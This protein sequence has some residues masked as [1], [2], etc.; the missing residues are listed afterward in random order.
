MTSWLLQTARC[1]FWPKLGRILFIES[2]TIES[3]QYFHFGTL[4]YRGLILGTTEASHLWV[5]IE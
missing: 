4:R 1:S 2:V 5:F 3:L